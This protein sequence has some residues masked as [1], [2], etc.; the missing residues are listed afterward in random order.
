VVFRAVKIPRKH[1]KTRFILYDFSR[2]A[3][4]QS[5]PEINGA[6]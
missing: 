3:A 4:S 2:A 6:R 5:A 1:G